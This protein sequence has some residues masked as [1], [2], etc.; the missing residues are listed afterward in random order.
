M[1]DCST[2][3]RRPHRLPPS[4]R[5]LVLILVPLLVLAG[6]MHRPDV[7]GAPFPPATGYTCRAL[8]SRRPSWLARPSHRAAVWASARP[9]LPRRLLQAVLL[10][11]LAHGT[12][13]PPELLL[14][15]GVPLRRWRLD[16]SAR[17]W[18][19]WGAGPPDRIVDQLLADLPT[20]VLV[21]L[22]LTILRPWLAGPIGL[23]GRVL[24]ARRP[25]PKPQVTGRIR[26]A[27]TSEVHRGDQFV[28]RHKPV[29]EVDRRVFLR[30]LRAMHLVD[31]P[32]KWPFVCQV[33]RASWF[34]TLQALI[35]RWA[36][37]RAA[38]DWQRLMSRRAGPRMPLE[39]QQVIMQVWARHLC[40]SVED[41]PAHLG[42]LG[43]DMCPRRVEQV[44]RERRRVR[45][46]RVR[47]ER[48][49]LGPALLRPQD[50]WRV[51]QLFALLD[52]LQARVDRGQR[53]TAQEV[54]DRADVQALRAEIGLGNGR[55]LEKPLPWG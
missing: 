7:A 43:M 8:P 18:P 28:I 48:F 6:A 25:R 26:D 54:H 53:L 50:D 45:A 27:G 17:G 31:R 11:A 2:Q 41:V 21:G 9:S 19:A 30:A 44:G 52:Q 37:D 10:G 33:W 51:Q 34:G 16:S 40:W 4:L 5:L 49:Q 55:A 24:P 12:A 22:G 47:R 3:R 36:D 39:Q 15:A 42:T 46:R 23:A 20:L 32:S 13:A 29:D 35:S 14:L 1:A 38:G